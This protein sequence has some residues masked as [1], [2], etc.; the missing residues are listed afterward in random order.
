[1]NRSKQREDAGISRLLGVG[2]KGES[3]KAWSEV[4]PIEKKK[5]IKTTKLPTKQDVLIRK[6]N[7]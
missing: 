1:M 4:N 3:S 5:G 2:N 7:E 6:N